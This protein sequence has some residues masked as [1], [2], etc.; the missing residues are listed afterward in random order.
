MNEQ[1]GGRE[2]SSGQ[3][4]QTLAHLLARAA[5]MGSKGTRHQGLASA[6]QQ[7]CGER[8]AAIMDKYY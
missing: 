4:R 2:N 5:G 1:E 8:G 6:C 3:Q 7:A